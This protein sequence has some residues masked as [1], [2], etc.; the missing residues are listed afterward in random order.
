LIL[1]LIAVAASS[2][3]KYIRE[4]VERDG[5]AF[6]LFLNEAIKNVLYRKSDGGVCHLDDIKLTYALSNKSLKRKEHSIEELIYEQYRCAFVHEGELPNDML[7]T[8]REIAV[9]E[10]I[11]VTL[12][13]ESTAA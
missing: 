3:K 5:E 10:G 11:Q 1:I 8:D 4:V 7:F 12:Y 13:D 6:K 2:R 9:R